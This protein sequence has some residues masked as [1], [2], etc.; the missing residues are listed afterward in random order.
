MGILGKFFI[1]IRLSLR[2]CLQL[3]S[4]LHENSA[5]GIIDIAAWE[6]TFGCP[7]EFTF[8]SYIF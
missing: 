1:I 6:E 7:N 2:R 4:K 3:E 8:P 5:Q